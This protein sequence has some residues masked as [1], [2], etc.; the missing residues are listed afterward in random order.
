MMVSMPA[1]SGDIQG[2]ADHPLVPRYEGSEIIAYEAQAY[3]QKAFARA[4]IKA[5]ALEKNPDAV[6]K[7]EGKHFSITYRAPENRSALEVARNY[8]AALVEGGFSVLFSCSQAECGGRN[9]NHAM[10]PRHYYLGFGEYYADQQY[11]LARLERSEGDVY[12]SLY[13]V[14]NKS[15]GGPDRNRSLIQV[16]V[17]ELKP[18]ENRMVVLQA[19]ELGGDLA[20]EG[21]VALYGIL[22]DVDK[23]IMRADSKPQ[24]EEIAELLKSNPSLRVLIVGHTDAQGGLE[25]NHDLS[26]RRAHSIVRALTQD[27]GI[28]AGRMTPLGVGMASPIA[29]NRTEQGRAKNRRVELV[30]I[31]M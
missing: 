4:A 10:S 15:G 5:G 7:L 27:Y 21:R 23:D 12:V 3:T 8:Q 22:F 6:L 28:K 31:A 11:T 24:L 25:Y 9:F 20:S 29:S 14:L 30:D 16:D 2:S 19:E 1:F 13:A 17:M 26:M 18:M